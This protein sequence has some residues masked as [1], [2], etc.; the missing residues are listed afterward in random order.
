[1]LKDKVQYIINHVTGET[2]VV[3]NVVD[4]LYLIYYMGNKHYIRVDGVVWSFVDVEG[5]VSN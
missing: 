3:H 1:M 2:F 5:D 4:D